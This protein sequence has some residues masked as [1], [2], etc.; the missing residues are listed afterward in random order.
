MGTFLSMSSVIGKSKDEVIHSLT[1]YAQSVEGGMEK[2]SL[3]PD[4][5]NCCVIAEANGNTT[6]LHPD[7]FLEWDR[8]SEFISRDLSAAVFSFHIHDGDLWMYTLFANGETVDQFN[9]IPDYWEEDPG[10]DELRKWRGSAATV[11][12]YISSVKLADI[13]KYL[14]RWDPEAE[15]GKK[16]YPDDEF[17][18][19]D[20]QL[21]DFMKKLGLP[22]P[23]NEDGT[24]KGEIYRLWTQDLPLQPYNALSSKEMQISGGRPSEK[25]WWK[26]W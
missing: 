26:F 2:A 14:V 20:W 11:Q 16:A 5:E 19:E 15:E 21:L 24:P 6:I 3:S 10:E 7:D 23:L 13:E 8:S 9:P 12:Q 22:Y 25:P 18:Q 1:K 17:E 4:N